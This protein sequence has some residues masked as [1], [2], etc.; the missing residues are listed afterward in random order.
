M[1]ELSSLALLSAASLAVA[2]L[3]VVYNS[4]M[5][6]LTRRAWQGVAMQ[7]EEIRLARVRQMEAEQ[8]VSAARQRLDDLQHFAADLERKCD[9]EIEGK[10]RFEVAVGRPAPGLSAFRGRVDRRTGSG[11]SRD[12]IVW[13]HPVVAM[14]WANSMERAGFLLADAYPHT[15]GYATAMELPWPDASTT[16]PPR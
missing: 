9:S 4:M 13:S 16:T 6:N 14:V 5:G 8:Q 2:A 15:R 10:L 1:M 12:A 7:R 3:H 11:N